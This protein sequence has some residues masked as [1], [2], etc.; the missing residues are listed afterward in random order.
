MNLLDRYITEV[1][2]Y[3]PYRTRAD[4]EAE[5]R[6]TLEDMLDE[7]TQGGEASEVVISELLKEYGEPRKVA[8]SYGAMQ[9]LIGPRLYPTFELVIKIVLSVLGMVVLISFG[10]SA[11]RTGLSGPDMSA[12]LMKAAGQFVSSI[13]SAFGNI[14]LI[15]AILERTLPTSALKDK[16]T[17]WDPADLANE[18]DP[19]QVKYTHTLL[20]ISFSIIFLVILNNYSQA[21]G[22][23]FLEQGDWVYI[24]ILSPTFFVYLPWLNTLIFLGVILNLWV[25]RQ[26][27]WS[28]ATRA[29]NLI[30]RLGAIILA[31]VMLVG[32]PILTI[33]SSSLPDGF[34][35]LGKLAT[36][37]NYVSIPILLSII[38]SEGLDAIKIAKRL[39]RPPAPFKI[40]Q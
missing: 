6:S 40:Q 29:V 9:Y 28:N 17:S 31:L 13:F 11:I 34:E 10:F 12:A 18:P 36:L 1:G 26:G 2:K 35:K 37:L 15:F 39:L 21:I 14:V 4:I 3:L 38:L 7:R 16:A 22:F 20:S 8:A 33:S 24:S 32:D 30:L 5:I 23:G 25:L 19:D 27:V